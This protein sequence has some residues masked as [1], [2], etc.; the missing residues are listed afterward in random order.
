MV[1]SWLWFTGYTKTT[2]FLVLELIN[3]GELF[4]RMRAGLATQGSPGTF[5]STAS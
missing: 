3:G 2:L 1:D 5:P 4:E